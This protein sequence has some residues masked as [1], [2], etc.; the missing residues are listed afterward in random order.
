MAMSVCAALFAR[1][2]T[3]VGQKVEATLLGTS[4]ALQ[5]SGFMRTGLVTTRDTERLDGELTAAQR[6]AL[7]AYYR[8]YR[9]KDTMIAVACLTPVLRRKMAVALGVEDERHVREL[10][11]LGEE[12]IAIA[13]R[14]TAE[15]TARLAERTT[16]EWLDVLDAAGV[17]AGPVNRIS[18]LAD[19]PQVIANDLVVELDHPVAE[20]VSMVGPIVRMS[21]TPTRAQSPPP[22]LGQHSAEILGEVGYNEAEI[23]A[24]FAAGVVV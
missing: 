18:D 16:A 3:G 14:F 13:E 4:L 8:V 10:P 12:A 24:L 2:R 19:D 6:R 15:V 20:R 7:A 22:T 17:P 5:G 11:R 1:E 23:A 21:G 9:T